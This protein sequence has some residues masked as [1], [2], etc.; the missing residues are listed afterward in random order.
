MLKLDLAYLGDSE[1]VCEKCQ[2]KRFNDKTLSYLYRGKNISEIFDLTVEE[3]RS[4]F[5]D[6]N[7]ISRA[8]KAIIKANLSYIQLGQTL[9]SYSGG[10]L[11][12]LK[13]A[14]MLSKKHRKLLSWMNLQQA[15]TN[16]I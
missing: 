6:N 11:Q 3:A 14:Q 1:E 7:L 10:E 12:R 4:V 9:D 15:C 5:Y 2:G 8:L 16:R 13:I